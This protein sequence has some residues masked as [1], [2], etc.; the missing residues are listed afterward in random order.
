MSR[1]L[2]VEDPL[3]VMQLS[4][5]LMDIPDLEFDVFSDGREAMDR[6]S[7]APGTFDLVAVGDGVSGMALIECVAYLRRMFR[8]LLIVV[9]VSEDTEDQILEL[10][11]HGIRRAH[12][13]VK[14]TTPDRFSEL[15][16]GML[17]EDRRKTVEKRKRK[18]EGKQH[19]PNGNVQ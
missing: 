16:A 2:I 17:E 1:V 10:N 8:E 13:L 6:V 18:Q 15:I 19:P 12:V 11:T 4:G 9:L 14:P 3:T 7:I 5:P